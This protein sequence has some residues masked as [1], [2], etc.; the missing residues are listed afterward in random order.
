MEG[1][2]RSRSAAQCVL[3]LK[4]QES[5]VKYCHRAARLCGHAYQISE[6]ERICELFMAFHM[7]FSCC[8]ALIKYEWKNEN[9]HTETPAFFFFFFVIHTY[10]F[11]F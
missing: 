10:I 7:A 6:P 11:P 1:G 4:T 9:M 2:G 3:A 5:R 8:S